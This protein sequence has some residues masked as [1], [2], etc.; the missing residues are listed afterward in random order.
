MFTAELSLVDDRAA[1]QRK[2]QRDQLQRTLDGL[3]S[4]QE[5]ILRQAENAGPGDPFTKGLRTICNRLESERAAALATLAELNAADA[6][7]PVRP[8]EEDADL[9]DALPYLV[10]NLV[11]APQQL[12]RR[13][14]EVIQLTIQLHYDPNEATIRITLPADMLPD[15]AT[16]AERMQDVMPATSR[17]EVPRSTSRT[18]AGGATPGAPL[19]SR[20]I[21]DVSAGRTVTSWSSRR[22]GLPPFAGGGAP[23][24]S[25]VPF[26]VADAFE[27]VPFAPFRAWQKGHVAVWRQ[28]TAALASVAAGHCGRC[29]PFV[30][31]RKYATC[32]HERVA[33]S[34][35]FGGG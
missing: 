25:D 6:A 4:R 18:D 22:I 16:T 34:K 26:A 20:R 28:P 8:T 32:H 23:V 2:A 30:P 17:S 13:L 9:L 14:F 24:S 1:R 29:L 35:F 11:H 21:G 15:I 12:L 7:E 3:S 10:L 31:W 19:T 33:A 5:N 27:S